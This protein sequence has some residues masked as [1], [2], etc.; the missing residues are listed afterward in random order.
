MEFPR[1][2]SRLIRK[3]AI[4]ALYGATLV[5]AISSEKKEGE[6]R[7][8]VE[9]NLTTLIREQEKKLGIHYPEQLPIIYYH[10]PEDKKLT[11]GLYDPETNKIFLQNEQYK[12]DWDAED[13]YNTLNHELGHYYLDRLSEKLT[14]NDWPEYTNMTALEKMSVKIVS[15][16]I[17]TYFER[18]MNG[19][20]DTFTDEKWPRA[21][22]GFFSSWDLTPKNEIV[23]DGG[24]HLV[25]PIID[26]YG[27][28]GIQYLMF[29][30]P[31]LSEMYSLPLYQQRIIE[32]L[33]E[34]E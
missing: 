3:I 11:L 23:Y 6:V 24:Y 1:S 9:T 29:N 4:G 2:G 5:H 17:A 27:E 33:S 34:H 12:F 20:E 26:Q 21:L 22:G 15:E 10:L 28:K 16:G 30:P 32:E 19:N 18:K 7:R 25:K 14:N 8:Y 13:V 31:K